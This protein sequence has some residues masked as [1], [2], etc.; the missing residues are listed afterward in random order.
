MKQDK[1]CIY[2]ITLWHIPIITFAM[3]K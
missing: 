1:Q 3:E 2:N